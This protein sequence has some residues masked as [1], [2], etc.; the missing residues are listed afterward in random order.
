MSGPIRPYLDLARPGRFCPALSCPVQFSAASG[1][2][3]PCLVVSGR[4]GPY[5]AP[6]GRIRSSLALSGPSRPYPA[7]SGGARLYSALS[8]SGRIRPCPA[9]FGCIRPYPAVP[10]FVLLYLSGHIVELLIINHM[11]RLLRLVTLSFKHDLEAAR[12][13]VWDSDICINKI[14]PAGQICIYFGLRP[15]PSAGARTSA[16][17]VRGEPSRYNSVSDR[18]VFCEMSCFWA[19]VGMRDQSFFQSKT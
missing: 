10:G 12:P 15:A 11:R 18:G 3:R 17:L 4:V 14:G 2:F 13:S 6:P 16:R 5:L 1:R 7:A 19:L 9:L 8:V